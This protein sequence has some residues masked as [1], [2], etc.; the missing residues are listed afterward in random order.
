[1]SFTM[2][3]HFLIVPSARGK[4]NVQTEA[5]AP[6]HMLPLIDNS[7]LIFFFT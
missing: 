1:M 5:V 6:F 3:D 4:V 2:T 7:V